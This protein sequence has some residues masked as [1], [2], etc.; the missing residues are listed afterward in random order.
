[1]ELLEPTRQAH[2]T[3]AR[4]RRRV[5]ARDCVLHWA[6]VP[7]S[8][9]RDRVTVPLRTVV[10]CARTSAFAQALSIADSALRLR[11][12][13]ADDL[14][15]AA[16]SL[17]GPGRGKALRVARAAD[18]RAESV[19]ESALRALL[20]EHRI[21]GFEPQVSIQDERFGVRVDFAHRGRRIVLE[22]ESFAH[23]GHRPALVRDCWRYTELNIR[24][25]RVL[26]F[27]WEHVLFEPDWVV[28]SIRAALASRA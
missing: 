25:W 2:V 14:I 26:R 4:S 17:R 13:T 8:D 15:A 21:R 3:V 28:Q 19:L 23:H 16:E 6:D 1:M 24:G 27:A 22:A 18:G 20:L 9:I 12:V 11:L 7:R 10:D 5:D